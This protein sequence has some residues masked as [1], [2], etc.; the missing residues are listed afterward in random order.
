MKKEIR[1]SI[2]KKRR[3]LSDEQVLEKS[4]WIKQRLLALDE[5]KAADTI[6]FYVSY[7]NEVNTHEMIKECLSLGKQVVVPKVNKKDCTLCLS[8]LNKWEDLESCAYDILEPKPECIKEVPVE[9]IDVMIVP[10]VVFDV[11]G[12]RIGHGMGYY[13]RLLQRNVRAHVVG[14]AFECQLV[15]KIHAE[16]HDV[17]VEKIITEERIIKCV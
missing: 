16:K 17:C 14:L 8:L 2:L 7:D 5:F 9:S 15:E 12:N 1:S 10:G 13:D 4:K 11:L 3:C 6:L